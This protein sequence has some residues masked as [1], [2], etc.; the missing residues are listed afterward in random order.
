MWLLRCGPR[1]GNSRAVSGRPHAILAEPRQ[2]LDKRETVRYSDGMEG[3]EMAITARFPGKCAS[4]GGAIRVGE[5]VNWS[6]R[7]GTRHIVCQATAERAAAVTGG[8]GEVRLSCGEGYGGVPYRVGDV[9]RNGAG[10]PVVV[11]TA[12]KRYYH[13]DGL[14]FGVGDDAGYIYFATARRAT[15]EEAAPLL[16]RESVAVARKK[17]RLAL[18][19]I[20]SFIRFEGERPKDEQPVGELL[21][22]T[23]TT[24]GGGNWWVLSDEW[25]WFVANNGRDGDNW[26]DNNVRTGGA[27]AIG[28]RVKATPGLLAEIRAAW[29]AR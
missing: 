19:N 3:T 4:C 10:G 29:A 22:D 16:E 20:E 27:G 23:D 18:E 21:C 17:A 14:S 6:P 25:I 13:E 5:A 26:S 28:R 12:G 15:P 24:Y 9:L 8:P 11:V 2:G 1:I 7:T